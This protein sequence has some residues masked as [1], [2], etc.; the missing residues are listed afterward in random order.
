M[1][2]SGSKAALLISIFPISQ[3]IFF[4]FPILILKGEKGYPEGEIF[5]IS[6]PLFR[7][8]PMTL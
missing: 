2:S 7:G 6:L 1:S 5:N 3:K 8:D 4:A